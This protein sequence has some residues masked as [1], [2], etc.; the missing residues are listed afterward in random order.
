MRNL[1]PA[2]TADEPKC[3]IPPKPVTTRTSRCWLHLEPFAAI[4]EVEAAFPPLAAAPPV[5]TI[6]SDGVPAT[7]ANAV[8]RRIQL[9]AIIWSAGPRRESGIVNAMGLA[10]IR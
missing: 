5:A 4:A 2:K 1:G 3:R 8:M 10:V 6:G 7:A 9:I